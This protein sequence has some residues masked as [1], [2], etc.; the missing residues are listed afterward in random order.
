MNIRFLITFFHF[1]STLAHAYQRRDSPGFWLQFFCKIWNQ[2]KTQVL[3]VDKSLVASSFYFYLLDVC[4]Q[5]KCE[6]ES[7]RVCSSHILY[8][9][10]NVI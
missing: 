2:L 9:V 6:G 10:R 8:F 5:K 7:I 4:I 1:G 3:K